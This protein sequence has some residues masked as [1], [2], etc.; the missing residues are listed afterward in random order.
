EVRRV[1]WNGKTHT[2]VYVNTR[3]RCWFSTR[4]QILGWR[5]ESLG[6]GADTSASFCRNKE[7]YTLQYFSNEVKLVY[8]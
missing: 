1:L 7:K 5:V 4:V 8:L 6:L 3:A 2:Y